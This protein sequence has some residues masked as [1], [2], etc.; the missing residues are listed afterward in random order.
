MVITAQRKRLLSATV[1]ALL[2]Q[3]ALLAPLPDWVRMGALLLWAVVIPGH[4]LAEIIGRD[5]GAPPT[6]LEW[7]VYAVGAGYALLL[8]LL[9]LLSY[10]P[11]PL[12]PW[13]LHVA[14]DLALLALVVAAWPIAGEDA[15]P[16]VPLLRR[17]IVALLLLLGVAA[18]LRLVQIGYAEFHGDEARAALRAA[19]VIQGYDDVLFL[20]KKGPAEI[21]LPT[22]VFAALGNLTETTAR[23]PF[24]MANLTAL[25]A[26]FWL[27][28]RLWGPVAGIAALLLLA[29]DGF[30]IGFARIVQYQSLV[31]LMSSLT[32]LILVRLW[33]EPRQIGRGLLLAA[34]L[35]AAG[36][37]SHYEAGLAAI[38]A[39]LLVALLWRSYPGQRGALGRGLAAAIGLGAGLLALFYAPFLTHGQF[40]ATYTYLVER[41]IVGE[42]FP[43]NNVADLWARLTTYSSAYYA[44][45]LIGGVIV[46]LVAAY[47]HSLG[48]RRGLVA[49]AILVTGVVLT[50]WQPTWATLGGRDWWI[51]VALVALLP[52]LL[53]PQTAP[54]ARLLWLWFGALLIIMLGFT[55]KPRTHVYVFFM[56][57]ALLLGMGAA[58]AAEWLAARVAA[59]RLRRLGVG[60]ALVALLVFGGY[61]YQ[62][63]VVTSP[64]VLRTWHVNWPWG[65][66]RPYAT[67][68]NRAL[69]G[70][71]LRN[72]WK[73]VGQL[74]A[75]GTITGEYSTNEVEYWT[76][77]WYT[78]GR[79]R[80]NERATWFF[81]I[82]NPQPDPVGYPAALEAW[83]G[84][85][86][87][88]WGTVTQQG[89]PRLLIRRADAGSAPLRPFALEEYAPAFDAAATAQLPL[90][91]PVVEPAIAHRL[92][93]NFSG[94]IRLEGYAL[95]APPLLRGGDTVRL[96]LYW[97]ALQDMPDS[98]KVF[99]QAHA[100]DGAL[101]AQQDGYPVCGGRGT[102]QWDPGELIVDEH[103]LTVRA[104]APAGSYPLYTGLYIEETL[105]RLSVVDATGAAVGDQ[106]Y[107]TDL[108]I[109][110]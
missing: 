42:G 20:H 61:V 45:T 55:S 77:I 65:Y 93:A 46:L 81:Q 92:D 18:G 48:P 58:Q 30:F 4:L 54:P 37:W 103:L 8:G 52:V 108:T 84:D 96:T 57:W 41:R 89:E 40:D 104:D 79:L 72:G 7:G 105:A 53:A 88:P 106:V 63:F 68:D 74:Y 5:F 64:E 2:A 23:L 70:F 69:F 29:V 14:V 56:P 10:L 36:L 32:L 94:L 109:A 66:W 24:A 107:L 60:L 85:R 110:P 86:Y 100:G 49:G 87:Q 97:R 34:L 102:W 11:G 82:S 98:Y 90:G 101:I 13:H 50:A 39:L 28:R 38:P 1:L 95:D 83:I 71:P 25:A 47:Q 51:A 59:P 99:N 62:M 80:C 76:P 91:Y 78:R 35:L 15:H 6:Q 9:L 33:Q 43:V 31:L 67:L 22:A 27:G 75:D 73:A 12:L 19:A 44:L 17:E 16:Q 21:L 26:A 3:G